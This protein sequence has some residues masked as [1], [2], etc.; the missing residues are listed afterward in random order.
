MEEYVDYLVSAGK[1]DEAAS[2]MAQAINDDKYG[3]NPVY[4][5]GL[6]GTTNA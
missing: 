4:S 3:P 1:L 5:P 6:W 2:R